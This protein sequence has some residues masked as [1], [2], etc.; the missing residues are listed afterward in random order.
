MDQLLFTPAALLDFLIQIEELKD[1]DINVAEGLDGSLQITIGD[2]AYEISNDNVEEILVE[3]E[4]VDKVDDIN[5]DAY[6]ELSESGEVSL[7]EPI[8]SG[9]IKEALK[10]LLVGGMVRLT[11]KLLK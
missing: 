9:I 10:T 5:M 1:K 3:E 8:Q 11:G 7:D 4:I 6:E 2:S